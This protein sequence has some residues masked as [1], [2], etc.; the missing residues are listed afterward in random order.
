VIADS[1]ETAI[2]WDRFGEFYQAIREE[3]SRVICEATGADGVL[4][5]RFT[6][7]YPDGPARCFTFYVR[8][9]GSGDMAAMLSRWR[10]IKLAANAAVTRGGGT[11]T[12]QHAVGRDRRPTGC[13]DQVPPLF[14]AAFTAARQ[15]LDPAGLINPGALVDTLARG[16]AQGGVM[17]GYA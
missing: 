8:G 14:R 3:M 11:V 9:T 7:V 6:H 16:A 4:S 10:D 15:A 2:T 1:F 5:C 13:D 12:L 17:R